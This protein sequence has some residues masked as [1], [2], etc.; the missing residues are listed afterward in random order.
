M[1]GVS[2]E[3]AQFSG[4]GRRSLQVLPEAGALLLHEGQD[5]LRDR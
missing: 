3:V 5:P 1:V 4:V 2:R